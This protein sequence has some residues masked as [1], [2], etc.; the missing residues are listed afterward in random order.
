MRG[1]FLHDEWILKEYSGGYNTHILADFD[2]IEDIL[3]MGETSLQVGAQVSA[4]M[5]EKVREHGGRD[6]R[7]GYNTLSE[8][9]QV[10]FMANN[11]MG[12]LRET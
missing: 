11:V 9:Q 5:L 4:M 8:E 1:L 3:E 6:I 12:Y 7:L 2:D 10:V